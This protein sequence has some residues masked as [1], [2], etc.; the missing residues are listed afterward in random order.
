[1]KIDL[2]SRHVMAIVNVTPDS[3]YV[4]SRT[5][6]ESAIRERVSKVIEQGATILD[7]GGYSSR[8]NADDVSMAEEWQRVE[9]GLRI[10]REIDNDIA[11]S[12]DTFRAEVAE[13]AADK[14]GEIIIN[15]ITAGEA[16]AEMFATVARL[17][18]PYIAM[19]MRGTPSTMQQMTQY[20]DVAREVTDYLQQ[21]A[22]KLQTLGVE[23]IILDPG[24]GFAKTVEQNY[25]LMRGLDKVAQLG[26]PLLVGISRKSMIY[27]PLGIEPKES[28]PG[29]TALHWE[30]LQK[31]ASILRV[32]DVAEAAQVIKIFNLYKG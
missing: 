30:A 7:I 14:F 24:F 11:I 18:L 10:A 15:D 21:R 22:E 31:G 6:S 8:P 3:F 5:M 32:H 1:M 2:N 26:S 19:H 16:D 13:R 29:T 4:S 28:L 9:L 27:K 25:E 17:K 20:D 12:I 23:S